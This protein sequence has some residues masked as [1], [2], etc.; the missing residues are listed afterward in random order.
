ME[1]SIVKDGFIFVLIL[2]SLLFFSAKFAMSGILKNFAYAYMLFA[3][4]LSLP[5]FFR[6]SK[7]YV[8]PI[9]IICVS[10]LMSIFMSFINWDQDLGDSLSAVPYLI[11]FVFFYLMRIRYPIYKIENMI[12]IFGCLYIIFFTFQ[13]LHSG[14]VYFGYRDEFRV[15]RGVVR[16][17]FPGA[18]VFFLGYLIALIK[19]KKGEKYRLL[20]ILFL[21][22][23][24]VV[25]ILQVTRQSIALLILITLYHYTKKAQMPK[26]I[27]ILSISS[28][29]LLFVFNSDNSIAKGLL[30]KQKETQQTSVEKN[31][32][33]LAGEYFLSD[34]SP[35]LIS[36]IFG[37]GVPNYNSSLGIKMERLKSNQGYYLSDVGI[38]GFYVMFG[39][40]AVIGYLLIFIKSIVIKIPEKYCYLKYYVWYLLA[41]CL[42]SDSI[43]STNFLISN[44]LSLYCLQRIFIIKRTIGYPILRFTKSF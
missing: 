42:T 22:T 16:I 15:D 24:V 9:Q 20:Y 41:T 25:T 11:W 14:Q 1:K 23:G 34:F 18:G 2:C 6:Y 43:Y 26:R 27:V 29:S 7:G 3:V 35:N 30:D 32:R 21:I 38:I 37:N 40:M 19:S 8:F 31:I 44:I 12:L 36:Q 33:V 13:F 28:L 10:I 4:I 5:Y 39:I 17:N